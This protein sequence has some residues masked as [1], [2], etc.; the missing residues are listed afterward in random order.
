M[1]KYTEI[2]LT[3]LKIL[4]S[5]PFNP[6]H[7]TLHNVCTFST[8][9]AWVSLVI[10]V[11]SWAITPNWTQVLPQSHCTNT[12]VQCFR[13]SEFANVNQGV[14][15]KKMQDRTKISNVLPCPSQKYYIETAFS[16]GLVKSTCKIDLFLSA[17]RQR[18]HHPCMF[19]SA[20]SLWTGCVGI[21]DVTVLF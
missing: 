18:P 16:L 12:T 9:P 7:I 10:H 6:S 8:Q 11:P 15:K 17:N 5:L 1:L 14:Y 21:S 19:L 13:P 2:A 4:F 20:V 3:F